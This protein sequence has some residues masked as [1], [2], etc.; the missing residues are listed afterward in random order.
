MLETI[1]SIIRQA[2][3]LLLSA[4]AKARDISSKEGKANFVTKYDIAVQQFL[5]Q[6][7][8]AAFPSAAFLGEEGGASQLKK[9][10][11]TFIVDPIDGTTNFITDYRHSSISIGLARDGQMYAGAVYNPVSY[12]HLPGL[13]DRRDPVC[14]APFS[15]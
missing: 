12:T 14:G 15:G 1:V 5:Q 8:Q 13:P 6:R 4:H 7:L 11:D 10:G 3:A 2:G 9:S